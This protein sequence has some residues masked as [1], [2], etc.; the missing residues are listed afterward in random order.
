MKFCT[1]FCELCAEIEEIFIVFSLSVSLFSPLGKLDD[2][3][4][5][6]SGWCGVHFPSSRVRYGGGILGVLLM[7]MCVQCVLHNNRAF[8]RDPYGQ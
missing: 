6:E 4:L 3:R 7:K 5:N 8:A 2:R 1:I